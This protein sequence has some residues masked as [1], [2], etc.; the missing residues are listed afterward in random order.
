[1][2]MKFSALVLATG[3]AFALSACQSGESE[4]KAQAP[5]AKPAQQVD[6]IEIITQTI[7]FREQLPGRTVASKVAEV[8]PQV[9]GIILKRNFKE[10]SKVEAGQT[11]YQIDDTVFQA[12]YESAKADVARTQANL[13]TAK[14]ELKRYQALIQ[15]KAVSQQTL[16]QAQANY[17]A[18]EA[19]LAMNKAAM[20]RAK[21]DLSYTK[22][23]APISGQIS[24]SNIT[25]GA[26]VSAGQADSLATITQLNP[27]YVD[28]IQTSTELSKVKNKIENGELNVTEAKAVV[29]VADETFTGKILFSEVQVNPSTDT[30]TIRAEF[31][32]S[33]NKLMPGMFANV[34]LVQATRENSLLAPQKAVQIGRKGKASVFVVNNDNKVAVKP[35]T[36]G[37]S[38]GENWLITSGLKAGD[39]V[40]TT[41]IQKIGPEAPVNPTITKQTQTAAE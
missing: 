6:A 35:V 13:K 16:D 31:D 39:K 12:N 7:E 8:R 38:Y 4:E 20:H 40:I 3:L 24:K 28:M 30:V 33:A 25:E 37:R 34:K 26:L 23:L 29:T 17:Q 14:T 1:M 32:N 27:I 2:K 19:Q 21:V 10:G 22:V 41:G 15:D 9:S 18:L 36:I 11:L 5:G